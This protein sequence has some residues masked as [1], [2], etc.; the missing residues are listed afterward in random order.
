M[1]HLTGSSLVHFKSYHIIWSTVDTKIE[2]F[3]NFCTIQH[4]TSSFTVQLWPLTCMREWTWDIQCNACSQF[5]CFPFLMPVPTLQLS[6][7]AVHD[8][9]VL[10]AA[11]HGTP[12]HFC[13]RELLL[14]Y[15]ISV[16]PSKLPFLNKVINITF[17]CKMQMHSCA[18]EPIC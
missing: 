11:L 6:G 4:L 5:T 13:C 2:C 10:Q 7:T 15:I 18:Y 17:V 1:W 12:M 9:S 16:L 14:A 8:H 3:I